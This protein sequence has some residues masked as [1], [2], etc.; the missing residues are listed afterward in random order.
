MAGVT[1]RALFFLSTVVL[2]VALVRVEISERSPILAGR[3][4]GKAGAYERS[5]AANPDVV[6][7]EFA[8]RM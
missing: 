8:P 5:S 1:P 2:R 3:S 6:N 4:F 7:L